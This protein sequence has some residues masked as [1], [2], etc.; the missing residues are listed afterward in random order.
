MESVFISSENR[1]NNNNKTF[2]RI[3]NIII[4][5]RKLWKISYSFKLL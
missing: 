5:S 4:Q 1:R 3:R 2:K